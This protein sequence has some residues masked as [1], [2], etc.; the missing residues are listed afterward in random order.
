MLVVL[1]GLEND[2]PT[3]EIL[4]QLRLMNAPTKLIDQRRVL[5]TEVE[6]VAGK[7]V[8]GYIRIG[9]NT[10]DLAEITAA[11]VRPYDSVRLAKIAA[12]GPESTEWRHAAQVDDILASWTELTSA[13]MVN[14]CSAMA[15]NGSKPYQLQQIRSCGWSV[16]ETLITTDPQA[17]RDFWNRH[18]EVIYKSVSGVRS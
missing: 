14:R 16:P 18:G 8:E 6:L 15:A 11:Y 17:A 10:I 9:N 12:A 1:W 2:S 7:T 3:A 5:E 4:E 13:L